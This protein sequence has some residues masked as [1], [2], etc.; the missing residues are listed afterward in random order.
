VSFKVTIYPLLSLLLP[1]SQIPVT[2]TIMLLQECC[3][4]TLLRET[5]GILVQIDEEEEEED[6]VKCR[7]QQVIKR[8]GRYW[9]VA[10]LDKEEARLKRA[11]V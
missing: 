6:A 11:Y 4:T 2:C 5:F 8:V 1:H 9:E 10:T 3:G 7:D